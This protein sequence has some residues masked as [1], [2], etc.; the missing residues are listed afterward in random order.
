MHIHSFILSLTENSCA[1]LQL[2]CE[3]AMND[4]KKNVANLFLSFFF[5]WITRK[6]TENSQGGKEGKRGGK[7]E[8]KEDE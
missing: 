8:N 2:S 1:F 5:I 6:R 3:E 7:M 4:P